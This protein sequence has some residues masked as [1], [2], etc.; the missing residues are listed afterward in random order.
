MPFRHS[1]DNVYAAK[2]EQH[3]HLYIIIEWTQVQAQE[4]YY[5]T[6]EFKGQ[7]NIITLVVQKVGSQYD[8]GEHHA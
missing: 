2:R 5:M 1:T 6:L 7:L 3:E 4:Y 8:S